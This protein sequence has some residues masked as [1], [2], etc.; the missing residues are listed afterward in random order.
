MSHFLRHLI[1]RHRAATA[2]PGPGGVVQPRPRSRFEGE[3]AGLSR[4]QSPAA[5]GATEA[6]AA[7]TG[8]ALQSASD[9]AGGVDHTSHEQVP[10]SAG[11]RAARGSRKAAAPRKAATQGRD[12]RA[13]DSTTPGRVDVPALRRSRR[14][15]LRAETAPDEPGREAPTPAIRQ[16]QPDNGS[17]LQDVRPVTAAPPQPEPTAPRADRRWVAETTRESERSATTL[18][19]GHETGWPPANRNPPGTLQAPDWAAEV[20]AALQDRPAPSRAPPETEQTVNVTIGRI[21]IRAVRGSA[22]K[23]RDARPAPGPLMTLDDYLAKRN[24]RQR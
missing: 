7:A 10:G 24:G 5:G 19:Q 3:A 17:R 2:G 22:R 1:A 6:V 21:E 9:R 20:Q 14:A 8:P 23:G 16:R 13:G 4:A 18:T 12:D 11:S 15:E